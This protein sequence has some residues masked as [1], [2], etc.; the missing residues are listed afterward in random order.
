MFA[1]ALKT[2]Q[3]WFAERQEKQFLKSGDSS[4]LVNCGMD[5][6]TLLTSLQAPPDTRARMEAMAAEHGLKE[7]AWKTPTHTM[8]QCHEGNHVTV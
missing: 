4:A 6:S 3:S 8:Q 2:A 7:E 5:Q 1:K